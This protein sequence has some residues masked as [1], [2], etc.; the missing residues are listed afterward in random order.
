MVGD[1]VG[2]YEV[3]ELLASGRIGLLF[4]ATKPSGHR[5]VIRRMFNEDNLQDFAKEVAAVLMLQAQPSVER[6]KSREGVAV[7]LA[8]VDADAPGSG[9]TEHANTVP[10][11]RP[12]ALQARSPNRL[13]LPLGAVALL[14]LAALVAVVMWPVSTQAPEVAAIP[15]PEPTPVEPPKPDP[16]PAV[17][18]EPEPI[19]VAKPPEPEPEPVP[20]PKP[21]IVEA[22]KP[23]AVAQ[24]K[25][26]PPQPKVVTAPVPAKPL[27]KPDPDWKRARAAET[28]ELF[29][30]ATAS[31]A[32][33]S[34][35]DKP[36]TTLERDV[37]R[38]ESAGNCSS[39]ERR[40]RLY[41]KKLSAGKM[42]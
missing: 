9:R 2:G 39:V 27:C 38:A 5:A 18:P 40:I 31:D 4:L 29:N 19:A 36:L 3:K 12:K 24:P 8:V 21:A 20:P 28:Q 7:L 35:W 16:V 32:L 42:P 6:R 17:E 34:A 10:I 41:G 14:A 1:V 33:S 25:P 26:A 22:P 30:L 15:D 11:K 13:Y 23:V 37:P